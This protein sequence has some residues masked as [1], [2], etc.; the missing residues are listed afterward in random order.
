MK[1]TERR[2]EFLIA[3]T[4][5]VDFSNNKELYEEYK[6]GVF[7]ELKEKIDNHSLSDPKVFAVLSEKGMGK[8]SF[9]LTFQTFL[10]KEEKNRKNKYVFIFYDLWAGEKEEAFRRNFLFHIVERLEEEL[11]WWKSRKVYFLRRLLFMDF[12]WL[13]GSRAGISGVYFLMILAFILAFRENY[14]KF[15]FY[16]LMAETGIF[17]SALFLIFIAL[18]LTIIIVETGL[19]QYLRYSYL[20]FPKNTPRNSDISFLEFKKF[21]QEIAEYL[22]DRIVI[23]C[24]E[25]IER[26]PK[27]ERYQAF[28]FIYSL[29]RVLAENRNLKDKFVIIVTMGTLRESSDG[30]A[31]VEELTKKL[32]TWKMSF[33]VDKN[34]YLKKVFVSFFSHQSEASSFLYKVFEEVL[35]KGRDIIGKTE[36]TTRDLVHLVNEIAGYSLED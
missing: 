13:V 8:T 1:I 27:R 3:S 15:Y 12:F 28:S 26:L 10:R 23:V 24:F 18:A 7:K 35:K 31:E 21:L 6:E 29:R 36:L 32:F 34:D 33:P 9:L 25:D 4:E 2:G 20:A 11:E 19:F 16:E 22:G 17:A 5:P 30:E 14:I